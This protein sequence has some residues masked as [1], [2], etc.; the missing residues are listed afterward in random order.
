M[1]YGPAFGG[2]IADLRD[3][4][5]HYERFSNAERRAAMRDLVRIGREVGCPEER[6]R[7]IVELGCCAPGVPVH[8]RTDARESLSRE[9]DDRGAPRAVADSSPDVVGGRGADRPRSSPG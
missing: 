8:L 4:Y 1:P 9:L 5:Q 6:L 2:A 3:R 7:L